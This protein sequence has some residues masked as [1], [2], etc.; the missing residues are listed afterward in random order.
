MT[1]YVVGAGPAGM[2]AAIAA[3]DNGNKV[4]ILE[5]NEKIGKKLYITGK[6]R[7]NFTN[8]CSF[9]VFLDNVVVNK[10]FLFSSLKGFDCE[11]AIS[12]LEGAGIPLKTERG[13]RVFPVSDK[14]S[15]IIKGFGRLLRERNV[16]VNLNEKVNS[17]ATENGRVTKIFTDKSVYTDIEAVVVATGGISYPA[18]GST[19]D[20]YRF[21]EA[22]GHEVV[23]PVPA[24]T[25]LFLKN[26]I[27]ANGEFP[28]R[29]VPKT[30][31][32]SLKNVSLKVICEG[33]TVV[34][35]FGEMLF[36]D[37]GISGPAVLT[38]SS[39]INRLPLEKAYVKIDLKPALSEEILDAR[40]LRDF[41]EKTNCALKNAMIKLLPTGLIS[42]ILTASGIGSERKVNS[43]TREERKR[44]VDTLKGLTFSIASLEPIE[45][46][47]VT[48]G[49]VSVTDIDPK[50]M[51]SKI[52]KNLY[53]AGEVIDVDALTGGYNIQ[54]ATS[55]G[56]CAGSHIFTEDIR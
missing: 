20:G 42:L 22:T 13:N 21:A 34:D 46:A 23:S 26:L 2:T 30:Q 49:G 47:V 50:T 16:V 40:I 56:Y 29:E 43:V 51:R 41:S 39:K 19:G 25:G 7:C 33:R 52:I 31:G 44:L 6:G 28:W 9:N 35:E 55:T 48:S 5:K 37:R 11:D 36:T 3:A 4:V 1:V 8:R 53:F 54:I 10:K 38:A 12:M 14:S 45:R 27:A 24:L 32:I 17:L 18:T 15:D